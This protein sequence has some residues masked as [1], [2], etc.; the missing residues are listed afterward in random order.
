MSETPGRIKSAAAASSQADFG[1]L[2]LNEHFSDLVII[3]KEDVATEIEDEQG[4]EGP[5][6]KRARVSPD[7]GDHVRCA[8]MSNVGP[9]TSIK[10]VL[11]TS[12]CGSKQHT[13]RLP[14]HAVV[15][16]GRSGFF[17]S[18]VR[19]MEPIN[20]CNIGAGISLH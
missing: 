2:F 15:L 5:P 4:P 20:A 9:G 16:W 6:C 12:S 17:K 10:L 3:I 8:L 14:G 7:S 11:S 13:T 19:S 1:T 18:K